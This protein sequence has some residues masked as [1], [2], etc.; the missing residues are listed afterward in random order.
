MK[1]WERVIEGRMRATIDISENQFG[2]R[3]GRSSI[4][5]IH[6]LRGLM[7]CY[8]ERKRDL[9]MVF[10]DLEKAYDRVPREV[11]WSCLERKGVPWEYT[12]VIRDMYEGVRTR[13]KTV[14]GDTEDFPIDIGLHQGSALS[15]L[16]FTIVM[17]ELTKGIQDEIPWC[18]LFADDIVLI[19]ETREGVNTKLERWR[20]TLEGKGFRLSRSKTE[21]LHC[22]FSEVEREVAGEVAIE[23]T[24]IPRVKSFRYLG[25]IIQEN[26]EIDEDINH[27]IKVGWQKW[28]NASGVLCDRK[29]PLRL[30]GK[31][32]RMVVRPALLY[33]SECWPI[34]KAQIQRLRVAEMRMIRWICGHTRLDRIRN[35][36]SR[37]KIGVA[38]I[39][40]KMREA[41]LRWFG[42]VRRRP[43]DAPVR[44]GETI[45][46]SNGRRVRGR[47][48]KSWREVIKHDLKSLGLE[49]DMTQDRKMWRARIRVADF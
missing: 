21:Y 42:H 49:E 9:H 34:K 36:V 3:P 43:M 1:V 25:S 10:I 33:G 24:I 28:K 37:G 44:R 2:F 5:A 4:E 13:V 14:V 15:P 29:I 17:D 19:D 11:L 40:D 46:C 41:R 8:R 26:G 6:L 47:P 30:K 18:M 32:Y 39:E 48:K 22:N 35:E 38:S 23:G 12:R 20:D 31:I 45:V 27:R 7:E 16:L